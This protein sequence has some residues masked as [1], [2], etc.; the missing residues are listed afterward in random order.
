PRTRKPF[1]R[2]TSCEGN[3]TI[4]PPRPAI[5]MILIIIM[6]LATTVAMILASMILTTSITIHR[7]MMTTSAQTST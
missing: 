6:S 2:R 5:S 3:S 4:S 7:S 1:S